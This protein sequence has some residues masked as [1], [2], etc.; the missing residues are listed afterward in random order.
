[1]I[2]ICSIN[3]KTED[4]DTKINHNIRTNK[5]AKANYT[6][7]GILLNEPNNE[8]ISNQLK[9]FN[10]Y[11]FEGNCGKLEKYLRKYKVKYILI[12]INLNNLKTEKDIIK[13]IRYI[14][15]IGKVCRKCKARIGIMGDEPGEVISTIIFNYRDNLNIKNIKI[16]DLIDSTK[17]EMYRAKKQ[18]Y[19]YIYDKTCNILDTEFYIKNLCDFKDNKCIE[20]RNTNVICGCCRHYKNLFSKQ[21]VKCK[22]LKNKRCSAKCITC[23]M[24]TCNTLQKRGIKFRIKDFY[25]L[26]YYFNPMQKFIVKYSFFTEKKKIIKRLMI[27]GR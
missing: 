25:F 26:N 13:Y 23:K 20:K 15:K 18:R 11:Y 7:V 2:R 9:D 10:T 4:N 19:D 17:A 1:M 5:L 8:I 12:G 22:Y 3:L 14:R 16:E 24:F 6:V 21:L 27:L